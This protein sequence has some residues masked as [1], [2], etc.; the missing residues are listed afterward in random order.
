MKQNGSYDSLMRYPGRF[1]E[2]NEK[3]FL[4]RLIGFLFKKIDF[5]AESMATLEHYSGMGKAV[6]VSYQQSNMSLL[7]LAS[8][9]KRHSMP[10]S[11][12]ALDF[13]AYFFKKMNFRR[14]RMAASVQRLM[15][16]RVFD[17][18]TETEIILKE[19]RS[20]NGL[21]LSLLSRDMFVRRYIDIKS[22][23][24]Q[25]LVE[26][27]KELEE[28]IYLFPQIMFWNRNPERTKTFFTPRA[29]GDRGLVSALFTVLTSATPAFMR[30]A[31]PIN[32]KE[33]IER[34]PSADA[35]DIARRVRTRLLDIYSNEKRAILGPV[36]K[37]Q[38]E[39]MEKV[40][41]HVSVLEVIERLSRQDNVP[42]MKLRKKAYAFYR[43]IAADFSIVYIR[44]FERV[45]RSIFNRVF[46]GVNYRI[47]DIKKIREASQRGPLIVLPAHKSH[48][49]YLIVSSIFYREKIIPPHIVAGSNLTF[50][51]M[52]KIFRKSGAFFMRRSFKGLDLYSAVFRQY[53]KTLISEGY[54]I[55][56]FIE[57]G[58]SRTGKLVLPKMGILKYLISAIEEGYNRD[59]ILLPAA[60]NYDRILE[61]ASYEKELGGS[62]K[63][64]EST[65][66]F[67]KSRKLLKRKYGKV[68]L[69][70]GEALS[71]QDL[72]ARF[73]DDP[74]ITASIGNHVIR[75]INEIVMVTPFAITSASI[76]LAPFKGFT[77]EIVRE[78]L[79][80]LRDCLASRG[81]PLPDSLTGDINAESIVDYVVSSY[82]DDRIVMPVQLDREGESPGGSGLFRISEEQRARIAF[83]KNSI[84]HYF[85]PVS[86]VS[87]SLVSL[88]EKKAI[89][90]ADVIGLYRDL[91]GLF[92]REFVFPEYMLEQEG[93]V[94]SVLA[95]FEGRGVV[96]LK[97]ATVG[98][99]PG[100]KEELVFFGRL[101]SEFLQSYLVVLS[102]VEKTKGRMNRRDL[103]MEIR[104][105]GIAMY[106]LGAI[107][108]SESLS[109]PIYNNAL[110]WCAD[111]GIVRENERTR[112]S[113][114]V[115]VIDPNRAALFREKI[116]SILRMQP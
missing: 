50:F 80:L 70:F 96:K 39:M 25:Y 111:T 89:A 95:Y 28:T 2:I 4:I 87:V 54:S 26:A 86:F 14:G 48:M 72:K 59:M 101:I 38:Q 22:D 73:T 77:A 30:I 66:V 53:L 55:E 41:Y 64:T 51:P 68:Y 105:K 103:V 98:I 69:S 42:E 1:L 15:S 49:D 37:S 91:M 31:E 82:A 113:P 10:I 58:R 12:I 17:S 88:S 27:Q 40:L 11:I 106:H 99:V 90:Y 112:K 81:A 57:G 34:S 45:M 67:F 32:L 92:S 115:E 104:K 79:L 16:R 74:D 6:Y 108:L 75:R 78:N 109:I 21:A 43:E 13:M 7:L 46:D 85:L 18:L 20:R 76:L 110:A 9:L 84:V 62:E 35:K 47:D 24:L 93:T 29:T 116:A 19:L 8:L 71:Y 33:E 94:G 83:Y 60:V 114:D 36:I 65:S 44:F 52:G 97:G 5:D 107:T 56:F 63:E 102:T 3:G 23:S 100:K 61:E